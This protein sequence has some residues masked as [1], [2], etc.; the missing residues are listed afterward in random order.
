MLA[1]LEQEKDVKLILDSSNDIASEA[2]TADLESFD[3]AKLQP[4][5]YNKLGIYFALLSVIATAVGST[6]WKWDPNLP[7]YEL[8]IVRSAVGCLASY[9][10]MK[11]SDSKTS[12]RR[13]FTLQNLIVGLLGA[14]SMIT[15]AVSLLSLTMS[16]STTISATQGIFNGIFGLVFLKEAYPRSERV[17]GLICFAG[18]ILIIK[19]PFLF[20]Q[21]TLLENSVSSETLPT[22]IAAILCL[23][24]V[25]FWSLM[26]IIIRGANKKNNGFAVVFQTNLL[27][28]V[29]CAGYLTIKGEFQPLGADGYFISSFIGV[30][31]LILTWALIKALEY[32][33]PSVVGIVSYCGIV[34]AI[35]ADVIV[36]HTLPTLTSTAGMVLILGSC[37]FL[38]KRA[39]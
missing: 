24:S 7:T 18:M 13:L 21:G 26:Q 38:V 1:P 33:K 25:I 32:E 16:E 5:N 31:A 2:S 17:L 9:I 8:L 4:K 3:L 27:M 20:G 22:H 6:A 15:F 14:L 19:P 37:L 30:T 35:M 10:L 12:L 39:S 34:F 29:L 23:I 11:Q 28:G 36:F